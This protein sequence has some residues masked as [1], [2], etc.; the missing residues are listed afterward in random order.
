MAGLLLVTLAATIAPAL[1]GRVSG[2]V[3]DP[4]GRPLE[5]IEVRFVP[6]TASS[7]PV[8][9]VATRKGKFVVATFPRGAYRVELPDRR[10]VVRRMDL[11][12]R[13]P[14]GSSLGEMT[15]EIVPGTL[16]PFFEVGP[17]QRA[18][19]TLHVGASDPGERAEEG[20]SVAQAIATSREL[21]QLNAL[22]ASG[23]MPGLLAA[24][25]QVLSE[26]PQL[27]GAL[28]LRG[29]ALWKLGRLDPAT[30]ALERA[31]AIDPAQPGVRG[32]LGQ[33]RLAAAEAALAAGDDEAA[34]A[35][36]GQ[37]AEAFAAE[38]ARSPRELTWLHNRVI[39]LDRA[40]Q[41]GP[42]IEAIGA[43]LSADPGNR[44][45]R[46]RRGE[47]LADAGRLDEALAALAE[48]PDP[49][50]DVATALANIAVSLYN[51]GQAERAIATARQAIEVDPTLAYAH[52]VLG[53]ARLAQSDRAGAS[54]AFREFLRL[55]PDDPEAASTRALLEALAPKP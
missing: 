54:S 45:A 20:V 1:A 39:A 10:W 44:P 26:Q 33:V 28:Y 7:P 22:M 14:E 29:V 27:A 50:R 48:V 42:A 34:K 16:P 53:R 47:L 37:A 49:G 55:A 4:E 25:D 36:F 32:V 2:K 24:A 30:V 13:D 46:L 23:D 31:S 38:I 21:E 5:A 19:I 52:L 12:L 3:V 17:S 15:S 35:A 40:G 51:A 43:L 11:E 6:E 18:E 8:P 41:V 9:P